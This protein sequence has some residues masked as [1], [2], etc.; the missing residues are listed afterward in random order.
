MLVTREGAT[1]DSIAAQRSDTSR[2]RAN[3]PED[4]HGPRLKKRLPNLNFTR[5]AFRAALE[6][7]S[8]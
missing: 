7:G 1:V 5:Q 6:A 3:G 4:R 8:V 2:V